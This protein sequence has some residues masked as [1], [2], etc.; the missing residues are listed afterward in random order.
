MKRKV[1]FCCS[2]LCELF[3]KECGC[4]LFNSCN[5]SFEKRRVDGN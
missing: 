5:S 1:V 2:E 4:P 3:E